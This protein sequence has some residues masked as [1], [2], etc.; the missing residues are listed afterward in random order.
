[1]QLTR[2][3]LRPTARSRSEPAHGLTATMRKT[4][5]LIRFLGPLAMVVAGTAPVAAQNST[6]TGQ[7]RGGIVNE[8]GQPVALV[9]VTARNT[10]TG[11]TRTALSNADGRYTAR[12]LPSGT[13]EVQTEMIGFGQ[14]TQTVRVAIGT[15]SLANFGLT[16]QAI[17]IEGITVSADRPPIDVSDGGVIQYVG[18]LEIQELPVL[19]RDFTDFINLSGLVAPDPGVTTGGQFS[20]AG[21]RSSQTSIQIDGVDANNSFFGENRGGSRI[22]FVFSLE[23]LKEFQIIT[24]GFD[25]EHGRFGGGIINVITQGGTNQ[26]KG[27]AYANIRD[28][29]LT[30]SPFIQDDTNPEITTEYEVQQF[31]GSISGPI[32]RDKAFFFL[33]VDGQRRRE[34]Q[35]PLTQER[36]GPGGSAEDPVVFN[37]ISEYFDILSSQ[38]GVS[39]PAAVYQPFSTTEDA[40]TIFG[41]IDW[42]LN[43]DHRLS[44]RHNYSTFTNDNEWNGNFDF[45]YGISRA[46]K[47]EDESHSF[48]SELQSV[49]GDNT[50]NVLRAQYAKETRPRQA[51]DLRPALQ[52]SLS[53]N[54]R[55]EY[56]GSFAA[57][58]NRFEETK[59]QVVDN[60]THVLGDHTFKVGGNFLYT[61]YLN[62][63]LRCEIRSHL[64]TVKG[65]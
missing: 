17:E 56:G 50:F 61:Q 26:F 55:I 42:N 63:S 27:S 4:S 47:L 54:Q 3:G 11:L 37:E 52:V 38:Y 40:I 29:A 23:S 33:S 41:R 7:I 18:Q 65:Q 46:E 25:V 49:L 30:G 60:F 57:F 43:D 6:T 31:A 9:V 53:N 44:V 28:D 48:V 39:D 51:N 32:K 12:L 1:M 13:Y 2:K 21:M 19:G 16:S 20:I 58:N 10:E 34:P 59:F 64:R 36:F 35:L 62:Q 22:P 5:T 8:G 15:S 45:A 24:N 14:A